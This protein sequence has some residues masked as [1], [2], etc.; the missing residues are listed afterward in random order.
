MVK[1]F[2]DNGNLPK[3][4]NLTW[5]ALALKEGGIDDIRDYR[6]ISEEQAAFVGGR[7]ILDGALIACEVI[8]WVKR[9]KLPA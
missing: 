4:A 3:E 5:V 8:H 2:F 6:P 9:R 1:D 7:K